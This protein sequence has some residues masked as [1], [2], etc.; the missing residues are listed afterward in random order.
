[1]LNLV[2]RKVVFLVAIG[3][4]V[5]AAA[6]SL[7][8]IAEREKERRSKETTAEPVKSYGDQELAKA[9]GGTYTQME[10]PVATPPAPAQVAN[11]RATGRV[12]AAVA[13][14]ADTRGSG[15]STTPSGEAGWRSLAEQARA[16]VARLEAE[17][18]DLD[19]RATNAA[20]GSTSEECLQP[21]RIRDKADEK[22]IEDCLKRRQNDPLRQRAAH[23]QALASVARARAGLA[24]AKS[25]LANLEEEARRAN[26]PPGWLRE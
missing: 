8:E 19:A 26:V 4:A 16:R 12:A 7:A 14:A 15:P 11:P 3:L 18:R 10:G 13:S 24:E 22:A 1:M 25:T 2:T 20:F 9:K 23:G 17:V 21:A 6:Q 5:D